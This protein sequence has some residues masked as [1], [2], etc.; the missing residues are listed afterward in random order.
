MIEEVINL[1]K[2]N[3]ITLGACESL[4]GG[5][6]ASTLCSYSGVSSFFKGS[7]VSYSS[8]VKRDLVQID[9]DLIDKYGVVS[10]QIAE[11]MALNASKLLDVD[12]CISFTGNAG[13]TAMEGKK[14]G[15]VYIGVYFKGQVSTF[16]FV[17]EGER[18]SIRNQVVDEGF[19]IMKNFLEN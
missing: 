8:L 18:N 1:L 12:M 2:K 15:L 10:H 6:F 14:V 4:T 3:Q 7:I 19:K 11:K 9:Q 5:L 17:F 13:P 16:E